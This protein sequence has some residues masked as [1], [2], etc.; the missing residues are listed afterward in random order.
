MLR[1]P[2]DW[3]SGVSGRLRIGM[4]VI[5]VHDIPEAGHRES[6]KNLDKT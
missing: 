1:R 6:R 3:L 4:F 2:S 5:D